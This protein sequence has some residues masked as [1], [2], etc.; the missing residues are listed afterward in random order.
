VFKFLADENLNGGILSGLLL[1]NPHLDIV[2]A[3]DLG[4]SGAD[5]PDVLAYA[6]SDARIVLTHDGATMPDYAYERAD[7]GEIMPGVFVIRDRLSV[8][9]AIDEVLMTVECSEPD[10]WT[11]RVVRLP[12]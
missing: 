8:G 10:E 1:R 3:Q 6:A 9:Q 5:D 7:R 2:R 12:L 4:L 11:H